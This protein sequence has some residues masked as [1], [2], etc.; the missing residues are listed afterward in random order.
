MSELLKLPIK[1]T[2][3][4]MQFIDRDYLKKKLEKRKGKCK[5]CGKCCG[6]CKFLEN[7][8]CKVY[9]SRPWRCYKEF[10]LDNLDLKV[11]KINNCGYHFK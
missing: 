1:L 10:P 6:N 2:S 3:Q 8:L 7:S 11:W 4:I 9:N 5:K